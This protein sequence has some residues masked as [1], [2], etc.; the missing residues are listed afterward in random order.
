MLLL[1][2]VGQVICLRLIASLFTYQNVGDYRWI[3]FRI[4]PKETEY[5]KI[6][7]FFFILAV[8]EYALGYHPAHRVNYI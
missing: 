1:C 2:V 7:R 6:I 4:Q 3:V 8:N 5:S